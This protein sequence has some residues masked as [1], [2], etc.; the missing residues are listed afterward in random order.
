MA[1]TYTVPGTIAPLRQRNSM[2]CWAAM[3]TMMYSWKHQVSIPVETAVAQLGRH[4]MDVYRRNSGLSIAD[5]RRLAAAAGMTA[6]P[7][8]NWS[9]EGWAGML[10]RHGLLW[11]SY[12]WRTA[13]RSGRHIIIFYGLR[14]GANGSQRVLYIDPSDG[15]RHDMP[16]SQAVAQHELGFTIAPLEDAMLGQFSQVIHY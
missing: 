9:V 7:L 1:I 6:E 14:A 12:A 11:T 8:Q 2:S 13:T 10:R 16:F 3:Y 15:R 5:N 4:Y